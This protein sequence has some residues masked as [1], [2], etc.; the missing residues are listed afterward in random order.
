M[1]VKKKKRRHSGSHE[2]DS[3]SEIEVIGSDG[4]PMRVKKKLKQDGR[5]RRRRKSG[6][7]DDISIADS[8]YLRQKIV[9]RTGSLDSM[10]SVDDKKKLNEHTMRSED[11]DSAMNNGTDD[12][13][14]KNEDRKASQNDEN[15]SKLDQDENMF[16]RNGKTKTILVK[17]K[18]SE[19]GAIVEVTRLSKG[20]RKRTNADDNELRD[21]DIDKMSDRDSGMDDDE[22]GD[23]DVIL[24][25]EQQTLVVNMLFDEDMNVRP[26][27]YRDDNGRIVVCRK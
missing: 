27:F 18:S 11:D 17:E 12:G 4:K 23:V 1:R 2:S 10:L 22:F 3:G 6:D 21:K 5:E 14:I 13:K 9:K 7:K 16:K 20:D 19:P 24:T 8:E 26:Q 25:P 15:K